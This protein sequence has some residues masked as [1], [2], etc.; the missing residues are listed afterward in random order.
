[1]G[2]INL[3]MKNI[4]LLAALLAMFSA[5]AQESLKINWPEKHNLELLASETELVEDEY[6]N[7]TMITDEFVPKGTSIEDDGLY[8]IVITLKDLKT[9][10]MSNVTT[11]QQQWKSKGFTGIVK[12]VDSDIKANKPWVLFTFNMSQN[13]IEEPI[14]ILYY[15]I[16]GEANS[17]LCFMSIN[18][19]NFPPGFVKE[20]SDV[21]K[22]SKVITRK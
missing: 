12:V 19:E 21:F 20:W 9:D 15:A 4:F 5:T 3:A 14:S 1:M 6:G 18:G 7:F 10:V 11:M 22:N 16:N 2:N 17:Y 8:G 13:E